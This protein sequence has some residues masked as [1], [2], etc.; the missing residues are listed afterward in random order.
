[1]IA[2]FH[3]SATRQLWETGR[4]KALPS[5]LHRQ[6]LKKLYILS[7]ALSLENLN[8][9]PGNRLEKLRGNRAGQ[10]SIRIN[11][12]FRICFEWRDGNAHRVELVDYH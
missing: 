6:A 12:K 8:V 2:S 4:C 10:H 7:A 1:V 11:D 9:P 5:N 3:D